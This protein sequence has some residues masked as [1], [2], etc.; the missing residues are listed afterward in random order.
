MKRKSL[1]SLMILTL[2]LSLWIA[3]TAPAQSSP[4]EISRPGAPLGPDPFQIFFD[5]FGTGFYQVFNPITGQY[6]PIVNDPGTVVGGFLRFSLPEAVALGDVGIAG[7][8]E[9]EICS[10]TNF[11]PCSDGLRFILDNG[12]YYVQLFSEPPFGETPV[13]AA[14]TGPPPD[15]SPTDFVGEIGTPD[16][17]ESFLYAAGPTPHTPPNSNFYNGVSDGRLGVPEPATIVLLGT[18]LLSLGAAFRRGCSRTK[19]DIRK[20]GDKG[21]FQ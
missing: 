5:E 17:F 13:P 19:R 14:D 7:P 16:V 10:E 11:A 2:G 4:Q 8:Q 18:A 21:V 9:G 3:Q 12:L 20:K 1:S 15:F 6:G